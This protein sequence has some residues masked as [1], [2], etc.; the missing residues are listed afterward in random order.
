MWRDANSPKIEPI[1]IPTRLDSDVILRM[2]ITVKR[3]CSCKEN[4]PFIINLK[5]S[6]SE[7][8]IRVH[9]RRDAV[10]VVFA[11]PLTFMIV[12]EREQPND[13]QS[14][15]FL[16]CDQLAVLPDACPMARTVNSVP[17]KSEML[18]E[19]F[20]KFAFVNDRVHGIIVTQSHGTFT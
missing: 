11:I 1:G 17:I 4:P 12:E 3:H 14:S 15:T 2:P 6:A 9:D 18:A 7:I 19:V 16:L 5:E 20:K 10:K 13:I 8:L